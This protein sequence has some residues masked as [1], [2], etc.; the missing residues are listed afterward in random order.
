MKY[1]SL[2]INSTN[3]LLF[4]TAPYPVTTPRG[5]IIGGGHVYPEI[6]FTIPPMEI[7]EKTIPELIPYYKGIVSDTLE[8]AVHLN[9]EG[10]IVEFEPLIE[11]T[12][13]PEIG[14][15]L[16]KAMNDVCEDF[17]QVHGMKSELRLTPN[18]LREFDK[19][20]KQRTSA[21]LEP[22]ME[23]FERGANAG[24]DLLSIESTGGKE[25]SDDAIMMC[26]IKKFIFSQAVLGVRDIKMLW[27]K[28]VGIAKKTG[29]IPGGDTACGFANTAMILADRKYIPKIFAAIARIA[30]IVRTLAAIEEGATG[31][32]KDCG[33]EGP[34]LKAIT[35]IPISMEGK[36]AAC[37]HL[38]PVGNIA[39]AC[40]DLWSNESVQNI[41]LLSGMAP[42]AYLEQ[43]EYDTRIM[44]QAIKDGEDTWLK[45]QDLFVKS[46]SYHDP[47]AFILA[48]ENVITISAEIVKGENYVDATLRGCKKG[49]ELIENAQKEGLLKRDEMEDTWLESLKTELY[50]MPA[51]EEKLVED[52]L[53]TIDQNKI[54]LSE[55][56]L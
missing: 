30:T 34:F 3:K 41:K 56:G 31:P 38:S 27:G 35:G 49:L 19:P 53:P 46:D 16:V 37:A 1:K 25:V 15:Q 47:Q 7:T 4:G 26:D 18:D 28:I 33:Y 13:Y 2:V 42:V 5:L 52:V 45:L 50:N 6:N 43:L 55:Y 22:M 48:P 51:D 10:I 24:G 9:S 36:T 8:R 20:P 32:D 17:F 29:K 44:N 23:L 12:R 39:A 40:A 21:Y 14:V 11:M 54:I